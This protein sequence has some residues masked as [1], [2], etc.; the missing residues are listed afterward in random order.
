VVRRDLN[1]LAAAEAQ[2]RRVVVLPVW[3]EVSSADVMKYSPTLAA[4]LAAEAKDGID[5][6][7][8][9]IAQRCAAAEPKLTDGRPRRSDGDRLCHDGPRCRVRPR[10]GGPCREGTRC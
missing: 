8:G 4:K 1:A 5:A 6:V 2:E 7:A 9:A 3:H 10:R